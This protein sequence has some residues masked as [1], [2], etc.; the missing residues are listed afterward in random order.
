MILSPESL[1]EIQVDLVFS[2]GKDLEIMLRPETAE[3]AKLIQ[4][5]SASLREQ[6]SLEHKGPLSL[7]VSQDDGQN[8]SFGSNKE[9]NSEATKHSLSVNTDKNE[10]LNSESDRPGVNNDSLSTSLIDIFA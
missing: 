5:N 10:H 9:S 2:K 8:P 7:S 1:G 3:V 6:L 4:S